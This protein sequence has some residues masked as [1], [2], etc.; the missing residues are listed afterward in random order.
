MYLPGTFLEAIRGC[1]S[2][3]QSVNQEEDVESREQ[4]GQFKSGERNPQSHGDVD[5]ACLLHKISQ[6]RAVQ[7]LRIRISSRR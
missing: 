1:A 5:P 3:N 4:E 2:Q 6:I 7:R